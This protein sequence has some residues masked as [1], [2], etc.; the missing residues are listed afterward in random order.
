MHQQKKYEAAFGKLHQRRIAPA[1]KAFEARL[2]LD[3][4]AEGQEMQR[5]EYRQREARE[6]MHERCDPQHAVAMRQPSPRHGSTTA[7]TARSPSTSRQHPKMV[8]NIPA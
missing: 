5:Q 7:A 6:P 8:A 1:Q 4:K 2:P 3:S